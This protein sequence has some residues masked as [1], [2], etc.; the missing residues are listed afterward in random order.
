MLKA[1]CSLAVQAMLHTKSSRILLSCLMLAGT[2]RVIANADLADGHAQYR[3]RA[4]QVL[5]AVVSRLHSCQTGIFKTNTLRY[6]ISYALPAR[7]LCVS[8]QSKNVMQQGT[9]MHLCNSQ[10]SPVPVSHELHCSKC[11]NPSY[12]IK[13]IPSQLSC[14]VSI[15]QFPVHSIHLTHV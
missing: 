12:M 4:F 11:Y 14:S 5:N 15:N 10:L 8:S 13:C 3:N 6:C 7:E 2:S 1:H 9:N